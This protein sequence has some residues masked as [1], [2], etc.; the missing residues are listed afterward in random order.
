MMIMYLV[1]RLAKSAV[2][3]PDM[4]RALGHLALPVFLLSLVG[5]SV[6]ASQFSTIYAF[7]DS[8]SD[9]GNIYTLSLGTI[10]GSPYSNGRFT[11][12]PVWVQDLSVTLG[13]GSLTSSRQGGNDYAYGDAYS[14][15]SAVH[16]ANLIDLTGALGQISQFHADH[17]V[18]DP[19]ALYTV[20]VGSNDLSDI[21]QAQNPGAAAAVV[22]NI[23][24]AINSLALSGAKNFLVL[25]VPDL[26]KT[27]GAL[28]A[29]PATSAAA[30][31]LAL[32]FD[33]ALVPSLNSLAGVDGLNLSVLD[34][35]S[36][37]DGIVANPNAY[38]FTNVTNPCLVGY[39]NY[40]GGTPCSATLAGQNQYLFWD[41]LHP[42]SGADVLVAGAAL[43][44]ITPEPSSFA[45]I[46]AGLF[47]VWL[48]SKSGKR[49]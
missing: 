32:Q 3:W 35:Y 11:N 14:G 43:A 21:L 2:Y 34:T 46:G 17:P 24:S 48:K 23:D 39:V 5:G 4:F 16:T 45:L 22:G 30:S 12:G 27:P 42:T 40:S 7:G 44:T 47:G 41:N 13:L 1:G 20:W 19:N 15:S 8:L 38:G 10:P 37:I 49:S 33:L 29:G 18:A 9:A 28:A 36:L 31:A 25:T 26:G 6:S